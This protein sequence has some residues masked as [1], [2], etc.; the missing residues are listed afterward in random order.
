[1]VL[2]QYVHL[3]FSDGYILIVTIRI[4]NVLGVGESLGLRHKELCNN[5][6]KIR[7]WGLLITL[8]LIFP[9]LSPFW[10]HSC[11]LILWVSIFFVNP[12]LSWFQC[13]LSL[14]FLFSHPFFCQLSTEHTHPQ[15]SYIC[16]SAAE[17]KFWSALSS[18]QGLLSSF[19]HQFWFGAICK[20]LLSMSWLEPVAFLECAAWQHV[21]LFELKTYILELMK[22]HHFHPYGLTSLRISFWRNLNTLANRFQ[23][24]F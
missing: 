3:H 11:S 13:Q 4:L 2:V 23:N 18:Y 22:H 24:P 8:A 1:M 5:F 9:I 19:L 15:K 14:P 16:F 7:L 21:R 20:A 10:Y 17:R 12:I 6:C